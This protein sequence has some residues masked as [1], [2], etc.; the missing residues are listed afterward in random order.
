MIGAAGI[1]HVVAIVI[2]VAGVTAGAVWGWIYFRQRASFRSYQ[3]RYGELSYLLEK[4]LSFE[5]GV[6]PN[7]EAMASEFPA[8]PDAL[9]D[10]VLGGTCVLFAGHGIARHSTRYFLL[11]QL[12]SSLQMPADD[13][14]DILNAVKNLSADAAYEMLM[15]TVGRDRVVSAL[16]DVQ[17][18][19][20]APDDGM[21]E[22]RLAQIPFWDCITSSYDPTWESVFSNREPVGIFGQPTD[23]YE[24][25]SN[26]SKFSLTYVLGSLS[27][28]ESIRL[29]W[30]ELRSYVYANPTFG[31]FLG[32]LFQTSTVLFLGCSGGMIEGILS[33]I[34]ELTSGSV[35]NEPGSRA[36][37]H[38][39]LMASD[40]NIAG[41]VKRFQIYN[42]DVL[43]YTATK[44]HPQVTQFVESLWR[45]T[46]RQ[47]RNTLNESRLDRPSARLEGVRLRNIGPF[48]DIELRFESNWT[49]IL[50]DNGSGK[51]TIIRAI[52][53]A[54]ASGDPAA[55]VS[56]QKL[57]RRYADAE[58]SYI[59]LDFRVTKYR[60]DLNVGTAGVHL[61][62]T[63][64]SPMQSS[65]LLVLG[66]P[67][68]R[69]A[70][71]R[72]LT[73]FDPSSTAV[74]PK[75]GDVLPLIANTVDSRLDDL[76]QWLVNLDFVASG[77]KQWTTSEQLDAARLR[78]AFF[79]VLGDIAP[80]KVFGFSGL[81]RK[82]WQVLVRTLDGD[83]PIDQ[84]SQGMASVLCWVG[85]LLQ[86]LYET[87]PKSIFPNEEAALV[88]VDEIDAHLH[89]AWQRQLPPL[90][91]RHFPN[92]RFIATTHSPLIV[93]ALEESEVLVA[94]RLSL[95]S[96]PS[97]ERFDEER[98]I[99][100]RADQILTS[101]AFGLTSTRSMAHD[102]R[103]EAVNAKILASR[104]NPADVLDVARAQADLYDITA[105]G[106]S[107]TPRD[108]SRR[109]L[110]DTI[111]SDPQSVVDVFSM[112]RSEESDRDEKG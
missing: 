60:V 98:R 72:L 1:E 33:A 24:L 93:S 21:L 86:R 17:S 77:G 95:E 34:P 47:G 65:N 37:R 111:A 62:N 38:Y 14:R 66:F 35:D 56:A 89:P 32:S 76:R 59:E 100:M 20:V 68:L 31:K 54:L 55:H 75:V 109:S 36:P 96:E 15:A 10:A 16:H 7:D 61:V 3:S 88:L 19:W 63:R 104:G 84:V 4:N 82:P 43:P 67:A 49:V 51:S 12:L 99:G 85:T 64:L 81:E 42:I 90:L 80:Y 41:T 83:V 74:A 71:V 30:Q 102:A 26:A 92:V 108:Q 5:Q 103:R 106:D 6:S 78:D 97:F 9:A 45:T 11:S 52:A 107:D 27:R 39:A 87:F 2:G 110:A 58:P 94:R 22:Q 101:S 50:G 70:S 29:T 25:A 73:G 23:D 69:G 40:R 79:R 112:L 91:R 48:H 8:V 28:P 57:R 13:S 53:L 44:G 46:Y 18:Q 105:F